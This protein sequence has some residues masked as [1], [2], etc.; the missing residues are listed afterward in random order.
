MK[1]VWD[2][3]VA[4]VVIAALATSVVTVGVARG[5][6]PERG[7]AVLDRPRPDYDPI[8]LRA[9]GFLVHPSVEVGVR[10]DDNI[11]R[12]HEQETVDWVVS[13]RP[14]ARA[15]SQWSN[16]GLVLETGAEVDSFREH[17]DESTANWFVAGNGHLDFTR[18]TKFQSGLRLERTHE[19]RGTLSPVRAISPRPLTTGTASVGASHRLNRLSLGAD[20]SLADLS[21]GSPSQKEEDRR[22][23][24]IETRVGYRIV[25]E[26]EAFVRAIRHDRGFERLRGGVD[27]DTEGWELV[28]GTALDLGGILSGEVFVGYLTR[29]YE[30]PAL[31]SMK[32]T[33]FGGSLD[34][35]VTPLTTV[36][37]DVSRS[38]KPSELLPPHRPEFLSTEVK[39]GV[40]HELLRNLILSASVSLTMDRYEAPAGGGGNEH[41]VL[42]AEVGGL[43]LLG[44][45]RHIE[46]GWLSETR[47]ATTPSD[48]FDANVVSLSLRLQF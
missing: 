15:E 13:L 37:G 46:F 18:R 8:G 38:A 19:E 17:T 6:E 2:L 23:T 48:E 31:P 3:R 9:G 11:Y 32:G 5:Q 47:D 7:V 35:N 33:T 36:S 21:H 24:K 43:W 1:D 40:D 20:A 25:P 29:N 42:K 44:R 26:Y 12:V 16:H 14:S 4:W 28:A 10:Y 39:A 41:D 34:W 45:N 30:D 22:E 27:W